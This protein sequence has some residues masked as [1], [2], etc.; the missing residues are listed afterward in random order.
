MRI[1]DLAAPA[2]VASCLAFAAACS[3]SSEEVSTPTPLQATAATPAPATLPPAGA[4][5]PG[6]SPTLGPEANA[7]I[8]VVNADSLMDRYFADREI[9][10]ASVWDIDGDHKAMMVSVNL[11]TPVDIDADLPY[12]YI[13]DFANEGSTRLTTPLPDPGYELRTTHITMFGVQGLAVGVDVNAG[14]VIQIIPLPFAN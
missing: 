7:A 13:G 4:P 6:P 2:F 5:T 8:A 14:R 1:S 3:S 10:G 11:R 9:V 12:A